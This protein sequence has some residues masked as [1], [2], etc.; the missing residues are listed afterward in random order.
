MG[1]KFLYTKK[2]KFKHLLL[3]AILVMSIN[4]IFA[5]GTKQVRP[6]EEDF[7]SLELM[8]GWGNP[9]ALVD[10]PENNRLNVNINNVGEKIYFG[11][12]QVDF[13]VEYRIKGPNGE[14]VFGPVQIRPGDGYINTHQE[15]ING[16][17]ILNTAGYVPL[18][19]IPTITGD[20]YFEFDYPKAGEFDR[21][22]I[23]LF[24]IT[25][26]SEGGQPIDGRLW[27]KAWQISTKEFNRP[28]RGEAYIYS[29]DRIVTRVDFNGMEPYTFTLSANS[30]G[31]RDTG[32][33]ILDRLSFPGNSTY[34]EYKIFL[35]D[36]DE[37]VYPSGVIGEIEGEIFVTGCVNEPVC[38]NLEV[39][40]TGLIEL[41]IDING[42]SGYQENSTDVLVVQNV[43]QGVSTCIE[44]DRFDGQGNQVGNQEN[45]PIEVRY[46]NGLTH[47]PIYDVEDHPGGYNISVIRPSTSAVP[48]I[49]WDDTRVNGGSS[50][51]PCDGAGSCHNWDNNYGNE[52][53]VNT[54]WYLE[55]E[56]EVSFIP[57]PQI[58]IDHSITNASCGDVAD[59]TIEIN[60]SG[61]TSPYGYQW[62][63]L[64]PE[65]T[66]VLPGVLPGEYEISV[67]DGAGC[68]ETKSITVDF[69]NFSISPM[70]TQ[71]PT[72]DVVQFVATVDGGVGPYTYLWNDGST[73][74]T[75]LVN[76]TGIYSIAV[77]DGDGCVGR[78]T[79]EVA[80]TDPIIITSLSDTV[81]PG[82]LVT[83]SANALGGY[84]DF[85]YYW[86]SSLGIEETKSDYTIQV[87]EST[88]FFV[89]ALDAAG[90]SG[91]TIEVGVR[92]N[93][94]PNAVLQVSGYDQIC[95]DESITIT[96]S[97]EGA[98][99]EDY[100]FSWKYQV[101][102]GF[103]PFEV[104]PLISTTY[105]LTAIGVC[106][107]KLTAEHTVEVRYPTEIFINLSDKI[108]CAPFELELLAQ[109]VVTS[110]APLAEYYW[111][112]EDGT[113]SNE[114][115]LKHVF[116][117]PGTYELYLEVFDTTNGCLAEA[118]A[119]LIVEVGA[120]PNGYFSY[121]PDVPELSEKIQFMDESKQAISW[122]WDF[123]DT[124][125]DD[126]TS[127]QKNPTYNYS[128]VGEY[129]VRL[130]V[131]D[132][133]GCVDTIIKTI[134]I[135][136]PPY[137][138]VPNSFTPNGDGINDEF[139]PS[140]LNV[141]METYSMYIYNRWG[142]NIFIGDKDNIAWDGRDSRYI[143][144][145]SQES[146]NSAAL[147]K[148]DTYVYLVFVEDIKGEIH[149]LTG[150]V[151]LI[152]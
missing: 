147:V 44:W 16:P 72:C 61:G 30:T 103:E 129:D 151:D 69:P 95:K 43:V 57:T 88:T 38:I 17:N 46:L 90:C 45:I 142:D 82:D 123:G 60:V 140:M 105:T 39:N 150:K 40:K 152:R 73:D 63:N 131:E 10:C 80:V 130:V 8:D 126:D 97:L 50:L 149:K 121:S 89:Y 115:D 86:S 35:N 67:T 79:F 6:N 71:D 23:D 31:A 128:I 20:F 122:S 48:Q 93:V 83:L 127:T 66:T 76:S 5:E 77:T 70:A 101:G 118:A 81:C 49:Y 58:I 41:L 114:P 75:L 134:E 148:E 106:D 13:D 112:F 113:S 119:G 7:G 36:P 9:F 139:F 102:D 24:D 59:G 74:D 52:I 64:P 111:A 34:P 92:V 117:T 143:L 28:Y 141:K 91:D 137:V 125:T 33:P 145:N 78:D 3:S 135:L 146:S 109:D 1:L 87:D 107:Q 136:P 55:V 84:G 2:H 47:L 108:G 54:W 104:S 18:E 15:A 21:R 12:N 65:F 94:I 29:E 56:T 85:T 51:I 22:F 116:E 14:V 26:V 138:Y 32:D 120:G 68:K 53:T 100:T 25:V 99:V 96:P 144:G 37:E 133:F 11:F 19:F 42:I 27:S 62:T 4:I 110:S 132:Y 124:E 98:S